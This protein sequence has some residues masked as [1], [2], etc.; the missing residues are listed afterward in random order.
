[1][2]AQHMAAQ[3]VWSD[4]RTL[5]HEN[6]D[7]HQAVV[8]GTGMSFFRTKILRRLTAGPCSAGELAEKLG[9]DAPYVSLTLRDLEER[10]YVHRT[11]DPEDR[12]RRI[13]E[14]TDSGRAVAGHAVEIMNTPP[15]VF[16]RLSA[17]ELGEL[18][19]IVGTLLE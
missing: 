13:V 10:G 1:M 16:S 15:D 17:D 12:R 9:S 2:T 4:L 5:L 8:V 18:S 19:R 11:E 7:P 6:A 3:Q 14:L